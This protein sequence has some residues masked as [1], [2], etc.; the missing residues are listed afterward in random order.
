MCSQ[1]KEIPPAAHI[2]YPCRVISA[3][4]G[5]I[6]SIRTD[7]S[8]VYTLMVSLVGGVKDLLDGDMYVEILQG[9]F[10]RETITLKV[11]KS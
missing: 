9:G 7:G 10:V 1:Y 2:P 4:G 8:A 11:L 5:Q 6:L 3:S